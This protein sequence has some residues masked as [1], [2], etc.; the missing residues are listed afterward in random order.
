MESLTKLDAGEKREMDSERR[1][2]RFKKSRKKNERRKHLRERHRLAGEEK[3][4][5]KYEK[6]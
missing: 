5:D 6:V 2:C 1:E 3:Y 4:M